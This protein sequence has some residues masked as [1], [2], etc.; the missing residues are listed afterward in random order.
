M[1]ILLAACGF[2]LLGVAVSFAFLFWRL[3]SREDVRQWP[4]DWLNEEPSAKYRPMERLLDETDTQL[5]ASYPNLAP[6][7]GRR[8]RAERRRIFRVYMRSLRRDFG[9]IYAATKLLILYSEADRPD[10]AIE[11]LKQRARFAY[12]M[13]AL[14]CLLVCHTAGVGTVD[15]HGLIASLDTMRAQ[16]RALAPI[17]AAA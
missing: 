11:L 9:R 12:G 16:L 7:V 2:V 5:L 14:E 8:L 1:G 4:A 15:V 3:A 10:L 17:Q 6:C 13:L